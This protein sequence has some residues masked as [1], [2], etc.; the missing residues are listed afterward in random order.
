M[1]VIISWVCSQGHGNC[2]NV[3]QS[4]EIETACVIVLAL[5]TCKFAALL[6]RNACTMNSITCITAEV[7]ITSTAGFNTIS[8]LDIV[9]HMLSVDFLKFFYMSWNNSAVVWYR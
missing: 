4:T 7:L 9:L 2:R 1:T 6:H 8:S 3:V 5:K